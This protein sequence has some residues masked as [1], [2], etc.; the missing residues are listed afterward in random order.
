MGDD[1]TPRTYRMTP[2]VAC[3]RRVLHVPAAPRLCAP[4]VPVLA[5]LNLDFIWMN[6]PSMIPYFC[7]IKSGFL[8]GTVREAFSAT[9]SDVTFKKV[10][11]YCI[12]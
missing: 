5:C 6:C 7:Q 1:A 10:C 2:R 8:R 4:L 11:I 9:V 12:V 3:I